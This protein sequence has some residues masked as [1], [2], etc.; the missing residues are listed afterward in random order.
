[1]PA[2]DLK[3][4]H[5]YINVR[6]SFT[7]SKS[8]NGLRA[9]T[10]IIA[11]RCHGFYDSSKENSFFYDG[12]DLKL[13]IM[14]DSQGNAQDFI[15][16]L[17]AM[18]KTIL[19]SNPFVFDRTRDIKE[20]MS[21]A[22]LQW[23][24]PSDSI[25]TDFD[26]P[27]HSINV[28][29]YRSDQGSEIS[30]STASNP[31]NQ[32]LMIENQDNP[33]LYKLQVYN[34]HLKSK[35]DYPESENDPNNIL[36]FSWSLHQRFDGLNTYGNHLVPQIAIKYVKKDCTESV[37]VTPEYFVVKEKVIIALES[38]DLAILNS[39]HSTLKSGSYLK[40]RAI[41]TFVHVENAERFEENLMAKYK[42][43]MEIWRHNLQ[44]GE[45]I[46][47]PIMEE[48]KRKRSRKNK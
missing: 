23:I 35:K 39:V 43:T 40:E 25:S 10:Y 38:P 12:N 7:N 26:S 41:F 15:M 3:E 9:R 11:G 1:M 18:Q 31:E 37:E 17:Y 14:F 32:Y 44:L 34:C 29:D 16:S 45:V 24:L 28:A 46:P 20:M 30:T 48:V 42:E 6:V 27:E 2:L 33:Y 21:E 4:Y 22:A 13:S 47:Q 19:I 5:K 8:V 36:K